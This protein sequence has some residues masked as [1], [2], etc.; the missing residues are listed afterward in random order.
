MIED[1]FNHRCDI[2]H[3]I[4]QGASPGYKLPSSTSF[5]YPNEPDLSAVA[6]HFCVKSN[7]V[8]IVQGEPAAAM[9]ARRS[10]RIYGTTISMFTSRGQKGK[11]RYNVKRTM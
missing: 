6:C 7:T 1:F 9:D 4:E 11:G 10:R 8:N 5:S 3:I 2:Y